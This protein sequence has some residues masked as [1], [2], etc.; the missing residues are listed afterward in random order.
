MYSDLH[1]TATENFLINEQKFADLESMIGFI[2][3]RVYRTKLYQGRVNHGKFS[4]QYSSPFNYVTKKTQK[5]LSSNQC[6]ELVYMP[7]DTS[8]TKTLPCKSLRTFD[9]EIVYTITYGL[10]TIGGN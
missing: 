9:Y 10:T 2:E 5:I 6:G 1:K 7:D 4:K 8:K 3:Y